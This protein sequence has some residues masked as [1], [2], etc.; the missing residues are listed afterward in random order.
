MSTERLRLYREHKYVTSILFELCLDFARIDFANETARTKL[1]DRISN[2]R[3]LLESHG[4][5]E[6]T[7]IHARLAARGSTVHLT[8]DNDHVRD[9]IELNKIQE[10][11][12]A[13]E[14]NPE[15]AHRI[16]LAFRKFVAR[17]LLHF[18]FEETMILPEL[19]RLY[20]DDEMRLI[21][22]ES[23]D[24]MT[25]EQMINMLQILFPTMNTDDKAFFN[26]E[27]HR[28]APKKAPNNDATQNFR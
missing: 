25:T 20:S 15:H 12:Q 17:S 8:A 16:Y 24:Q 13:C 5:Y 7:R 4:N 9:L 23:Y 1:A 18:D 10:E 26:S 14:G 27:L 28:A 11:I 19:Q 6:E 22:K 3:A 21:D 2:L